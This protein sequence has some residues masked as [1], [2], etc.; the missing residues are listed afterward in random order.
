M[1]VQSSASQ[2]LLTGCWILLSVADRTIEYYCQLL[3]GLLD[4]NVSC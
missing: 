4:T 1:L 3:T 2:Q